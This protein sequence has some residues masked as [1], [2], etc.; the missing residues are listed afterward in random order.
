M[1]S[2]TIHSDFG[3]QENKICHCFHFFP[4]YL[5]WSGGTGA[6]ILVFWILNFKATFSLS[7]FTFIKRLFSSS[8]LSV[9]RLVSSVQS[10]SQSCP[11]LCDPMDGSTSFFPVHHQLQELNKGTLVCSQ[12]H[13]LEKTLMLGKI[14]GRR[15]KGWQRRRWLDGITDSKDKSLSKLQEIVNDRKA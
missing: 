9:I 15:R 8:S 11:T 3:A 14:E 2:V 4:F 5:P 12:A 6:M 7:F 10:V 13:S 1:A